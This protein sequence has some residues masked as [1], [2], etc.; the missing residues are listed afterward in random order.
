MLIGLLCDCVRN[1]GWI[2]WPSGT[3][4]CIKWY[5][6]KTSISC[7]L[8]QCECC[9]QCLWL[10]YSLCYS[11]IYGKLINKYIHFV[12]FDVLDVENLSNSDAVRSYQEQLLEILMMYTNERYPNIP[13]KFGH[14]LMKQAELSRTCYLAKEQ[15]I[16]YERSGKIP[17][18]SLLHELLKGD[19]PLHWCMSC[20]PMVS[21][22]LTRGNI[23]TILKRSW[24]GVELEAFAAWKAIHSVRFFKKMRRGSVCTCPKIFNSLVEQIK[25]QKLKAHWGH[26]WSSGVDSK[27]HWLPSGQ[28]N[29]IGRAWRLCCLWPMVPHFLPES[30]FHFAL[31]FGMSSKYLMFLQSSLFLSYLCA[32]SS[33]SPTCIN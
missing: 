12:C 15:L 27:T 29:D 22:N 13:N 23:R 2:A 33:I 20:D 19:L 5:I 14:L 3:R 26:R 28:S 17:A 7:F 16:P 24:S 1:C 8:L 11:T 18:Q 10:W 21:V 31:C 9:Q 32:S 6:F 4:F 30:M 25:N